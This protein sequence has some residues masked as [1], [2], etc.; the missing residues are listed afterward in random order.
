MLAASGL[1][2]GEALIGLVTS[3][4]NVVSGALWQ[5]FNQPSYLIGIAVM[6]LLG[7][8]LVKTSIG[9]AGRPEE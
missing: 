6:V 9:H 1:I 7:F 8:G 4:F 5:A 2:A 3:G